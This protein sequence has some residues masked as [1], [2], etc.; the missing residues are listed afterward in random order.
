MRRVAAT[1]V[2]LASTA[3]AADLVRTEAVGLRFAHPADWKRV[4][5]SSDVR[6]AQFAVP[7]AAAD[8]EDAEA[9]LFFFGKGKGGSAQENLDRWYSQFQGT[10]GHSAKDD[11]VVT[12][13]T[14]HGLKVTS[15]DLA[16]TYTGMGA[17]APAKPNQRLLA[18]VIE[19]EDGPWFWKIVG[20]TATIAQAKPGFEE[21]LLSVEPHR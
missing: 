9:I 1:I 15:V 14:V 18:A 17:G 13:R 19:G 2:F 21:L 6:A 11:A 20:P 7:H 3:L 10:E 12:I 8:P 16:G 5:A 4:P